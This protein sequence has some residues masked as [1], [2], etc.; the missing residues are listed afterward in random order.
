MPG[1]PSRIAVA[2]YSSSEEAARAYATV[3]SAATQT[4]SLLLTGNGPQAR[5]GLSHYAPLLA[6][7]HAVLVAARPSEIQSIVKTLRGT[8]EP[9]IFLVAEHVP[10]RTAV[11]DSVPTMSIAEMARQCAERRNPSPLW[12]N[13]ILS[14]VRDSEI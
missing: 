13:Q 9:S 10:E 11:R 1:K 8:G 3:R 12:K 4:E 5:S 6:G 2:I 7:D 14:R